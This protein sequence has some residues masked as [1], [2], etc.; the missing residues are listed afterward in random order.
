MGEQGNGSNYSWTNCGSNYPN[1][2]FV[3]P[4]THD[5]RRVQKENE[6]IDPRADRKKKSVNFADWWRKLKGTEQSKPLY[7]ASPRLSYF[8]R[9]LAEHGLSWG[10][11]IDGFILNSNMR[12]QVII[13]TRYTKKI[14]LEDYDPAVF[15]SPHYTRAGDYKTWEPVVLLASMLEAPLFLFTFERKSDRE[16]IGFAIVDS[17]STQEL[18]YQDIPPNKN[19][20]E[21][22]ENIR[23]QIMK[24]LSRKRAR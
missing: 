9:L 19:I 13:E 17:I 16:R 20:T 18:K 6:S 21:G 15:F 24:N 10:G 11:N 2:L 4:I 1:E 22:I 23:H 5:R 3:I 14:P 12:T 7:K 8:D